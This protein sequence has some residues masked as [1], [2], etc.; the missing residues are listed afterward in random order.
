MKCV[1][2]IPSC[3]ESLLQS[4]EECLKAVCWKWG[5]FADILKK[6]EKCLVAHWYPGT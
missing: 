3:K 2:S 5:F 1:P 4:C 6:I